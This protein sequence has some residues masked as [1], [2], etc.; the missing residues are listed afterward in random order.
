MN[1]ITQAI[2]FLESLHPAHGDLRPENIL[3]DGNKIKVTDFDNA[4]AFGT[5]FMVLP[6]AVAGLLGPRTEQFALG[7]IY[8]YINYGMEVYGDKTLTDV[9]RDRGLAL[10][11]LLQAMEF[12]A[13]DCDPMIDELTHKCWHNQFPTVAS[14]AVAT[15][16]L[17]N[18]RSS[19]EESKAVT[20]EIN[21][22]LATDGGES[23]AGNLT[24]NS[25]SKR[26]LCRKLEEHGLFGFLRPIK[27]C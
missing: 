17:L 5:P 19:G 1:D 27:P 16:A 8:Y 10:R 3:I 13:L 26:A 6:R 18:K 14:L 23:D 20:E 9:P 7:S 12:P 15:N 11:D 4:A 21:V 24:G 2:A 25:A 22:K